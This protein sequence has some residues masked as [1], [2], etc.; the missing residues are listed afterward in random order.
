MKAQ[1][2]FR[3]DDL[4]SNYTKVPNAII[5]RTDLSWKAKAILIYLLS[6]PPFWDVR[7][8]DIDNHGTEGKDSVRKALK[9]LEDAGY[10]ERREVREKGRI[11][12]VYRVFS[13]PQGDHRDRKAG[14]GEPVAASD[15]QEMTEGERTEKKDSPTE[16]GGGSENE[17]KPT[18]AKKPSNPLHTPFRDWWVAEYTRR[19]G[20]A[21]AW[22]FGKD[23]KA[24]NQLLAVANN[25]IEFLKAA[26]HRFFN[27]DS[28]WVKGHGIGLFLSRLDRYREQVAALRPRGLFSEPLPRNGDSVQGALDKPIKGITYY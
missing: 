19:F 28:D 27:D 7:M 16:N 11:V 9:E 8:C 10:F 14:R 4:D 13:A 17:G 24:V 5:N 6:K 18:S 12:Y 15:P 25:D 26:A 20:Y 23:G 3:N 2:I 21:P 22:S 1:S